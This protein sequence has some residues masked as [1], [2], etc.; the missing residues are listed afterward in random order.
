MGEVLEINDEFEKLP[1]IQVQQLMPVIAALEQLGQGNYC[2]LKPNWACCGNQTFEE[3]ST[4][5]KAEECKFI[6]PMH[7]L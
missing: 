3:L 7:I 5:Q 6:V 4:A 1:P 2:E